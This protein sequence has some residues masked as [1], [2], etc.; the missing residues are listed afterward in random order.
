[1]Q[2]LAL[3]EVALRFVLI[4]NATKITFLSAMVIPLCLTLSEPRLEEV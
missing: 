3:K 2:G 4:A 1:M